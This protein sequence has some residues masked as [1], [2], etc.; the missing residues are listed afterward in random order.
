MNKI[1]SNFEV[2][3]ESQALFDSARTFSLLLRD[4][5]GVFA[6]FDGV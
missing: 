1:W 6:D 2:S 4:V 3:S 5:L